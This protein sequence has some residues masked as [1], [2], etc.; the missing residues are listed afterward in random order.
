MRASLSFKQLALDVWL[1]ETFQFGPKEGFTLEELQALWREHG[2]DG[3]EL[4]RMT[5]WRHR[6]YIRE[7]FG[8][9]IDSPDRKHYRISNPDHLHLDGFANRLLSSMQ[10]YLFLDEVSDLG[11]K[12]QPEQI[13]AGLQYLH[14]IALALRSNQKL[15]IV[16]QKFS[17]SDPY[18]AI[19]WPYCMKANLGRW[20]ILAHKEDDERNIPAQT[21]AL[22][23]VL[24]LE[25]LEETFAPNPAINPATY[26][27]DA[28]GIWVDD[29]WP[30]QDVLIAVSPY[31]AHYF[32]T[33]PLH[34]SQRE[35]K[36]RK[37]M[38]D[39]VIFRYHII[40]SPEFLG[41]LRRWGDQVQL[42]TETKAF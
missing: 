32:R 38:P 6:Q 14:T 12:V 34:H 30:A 4:N 42:L 29:R 23:R 2:S 16:Y 9:H 13:W 39:R 1:I 37:D 5:L 31:V 19:L 20:Y 36:P 17:D 28:F 21:F 22:D 7:I 3:E 24:S 11:P 25:L 18:E 15:R 41:E 27:D 8:I 33:L 26:F 35:L 40:P 10:S